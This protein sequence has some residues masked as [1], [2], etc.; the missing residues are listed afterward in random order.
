VNARLGC[1]AAIVGDGRLLLIKRLKAPEAGC[2]SLPGGKVDFGERVA[3]AVKR[4]IAE[5][6]GLT[7]ELT[8]PLGLVEMIG[9]EHWVSPIYEA[10]IRSGEPVNREPAKHEGFVWAD[11]DQP[12]APLTQAAREAISILKRS[13]S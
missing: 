8:R 7:I 13:S 10:T 9:E 6:L 1:G 4:E 12:P 11:L 3:E 5:E 2:W